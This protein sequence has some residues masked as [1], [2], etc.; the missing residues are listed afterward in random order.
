MSRAFKKNARGN[1]EVIKY[2]DEAKTSEQ[3]KEIATNIFGSFREF[4]RFV[5][6]NVSSIADQERMINIRRELLEKQIEKT[7]EEKQPIDK[8]SLLVR[9][10]NLF[11]YNRGRKA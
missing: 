11:K 2:Y 9:F 1:F 5:K 3:A 7:K 4:K 6:N 10:T 8:P